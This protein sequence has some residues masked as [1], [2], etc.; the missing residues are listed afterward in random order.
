MDRNTLTGLLIIGGLLIGYSWFTQPSDSELAAAKSQRDSLR[1]LEETEARASL[2]TVIKAASYVHEAV[3]TETKDSA[4]K[5]EQAIRFGGFSTARDGDLKYSTIENEKMIVTLSNKGGRMVSVELKDYKTF[6]QKSLMLFD[7]DS[8][9]FNLNFLYE[10]NYL[11]TSDFFF[12]PS[13]VDVSV[14]G[15][16]RLVFTYRLYAGSSSKYIEYRY[17]LDGD[18]YVLDY[19][20][21]MVGLADIAVANNN[22][23]NFEWS[24]ASP[25][26]EKSVKQQQLYTTMFFQ[27]FEDDAD[28]IGE[29]KAERQI[30]EETTSWIAFKQ[31]FFSAVIISDQGIQ[32]QEAYVE[33]QNVAEGSNYVKRLTASFPLALDQS[34]NPTGNLSFFLGPNKYDILQQYGIGLEDQIDLGWGFIGWTNEFLI[35]P[36]FNLLEGLNITYGIIILLLTIFIKVILFPLVW[37]NYIS[38]AKMKV[39]KP[40]MDEINEKFK[41]AEPMKK[42]QEVMGLYKEAGVNPLAGC[43]PM[44]LQMPILYAMFRFF[45]SSI[46]LRQQGFLWAE[47]LSTY[48]AIVTWDAQIPLLSSFYGNHISLFTLLMAASLFFYTRTNMQMTMNTGPQAGQMKVMMYI[49]PF[50]LLFFFNSYSSGLSYYYF[51]ANVVSMLQQAVIKKWFINEEQIHAKI[52]ANKKRPGSKK[53]SRFQQTMED[54]AKKRGLKLPKK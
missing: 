17:A 32:A 51:T 31:Q 19:S 27:Y 45:P 52:Q 14:Q 29:S 44:V 40:E 48:D 43:I 21:S 15:K 18:A 25:S 24:M 35:I 22:R 13:D 33:T 3:V 10:G 39:L 47:D 49:M 16:D 50:M 1:A 34:A 30:L 23:M 8:S 5:A 42:Q 2:D 41:D 46:E 38:S 9:R 54:A 37:K 12:E 26:K 11:S 36:V 53:K 28:Y 7:E 20:V 6:E 4:W